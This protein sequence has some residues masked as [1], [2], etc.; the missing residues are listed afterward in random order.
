MTVVALSSHRRHVVV[1]S[2]HAVGTLSSCCRLHCHIDSSWF[3]Y[4]TSACLLNYA[5][6]KVGFQ[7]CSWGF[8]L[9]IENVARAQFLGRISYFARRLMRMVSAVWWSCP[10]DG[11]SCCGLGEEEKTKFLKKISSLERKVE[12]LRAY[13]KRSMIE[14]NVLLFK[15]VRRLSQ[16]SK[17]ELPSEK[18]VAWKHSGVCHSNWISILLVAQFCFCSVEV[19]VCSFCSW[20][21]MG[22]CCLAFCFCVSWFARSWHDPQTC[23]S[24]RRRH[25]TNYARRRRLGAH[26][27]FL[28]ID[29]CRAIDDFISNCPVQM[30]FQEKE[31]Q[32]CSVH[33][34]ISQTWLR[35]ALWAVACDPIFRTPRRVDLGSVKRFH[36]NA[37]NFEIFCSNLHP[38][39]PAIGCDQP[40]DQRAEG[41]QKQ[42]A[43]D[44]ELL[45]EMDQVSGVGRSCGFLSP[46]ICFER[47]PLHVFCSILSPVLTWLRVPEVLWSRWDHGWSFDG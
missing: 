26:L 32:T 7:Q 38:R 11:I 31:S 22:R 20:G 39:G 8:A 44:V 37:T 21:L 30:F 4:P 2:R 19:A 29:W 15:D 14:E 40:F 42:H 24:E 35:A 46:S 13:K 41:L 25:L 9:G 28:K 10:G 45:K 1:S 47:D 34:F 12:T 5:K 6:S 43:Q 16:V 27:C 3:S 23:V 33:V 18:F 36:P 17:W